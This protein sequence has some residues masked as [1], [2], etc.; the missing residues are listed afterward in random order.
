MFNVALSESGN[1]RKFLFCG[2][3]FME[4]KLRAN[5]Y[6]FLK[7][8]RKIEATVSC[9]KNVDVTQKNQFSPK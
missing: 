8:D 7:K 1:Q 4:F 9:K 5:A 3:I 2:E 6:F